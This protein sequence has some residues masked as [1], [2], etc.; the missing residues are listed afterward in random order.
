M[1]KKVS[2]VWFIYSISKWGGVN[3]IGK[4]ITN[5]FVGNLNKMLLRIH[6]IFEKSKI[7][8]FSV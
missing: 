2:E 1:F 3:H 5:F 7:Q 6:T 4:P 8:K